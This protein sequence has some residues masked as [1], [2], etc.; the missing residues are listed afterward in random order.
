MHP[1]IDEV[2]RRIVEER[3]AEK[4][5]GKPIHERLYELNKEIQDKKN[6]MRE[7]E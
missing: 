7:V 2:S 4:R 3:L 1:V 6:Y 5:G